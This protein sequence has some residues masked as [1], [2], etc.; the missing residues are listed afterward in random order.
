MVEQFT[1]ITASISFRNELNNNKEVSKNISMEDE[2]NTLNLHL[3]SNSVEMMHTSNLDESIQPLSSQ[4]PNPVI[5]STQN[6][7]SN[8]QF[9]LLREPAFIGK[10]DKRGRKTYAFIK[11]FESLIELDTFLRTEN[12]SNIITTHNT[13]VNCTQC[14][15]YKDCAKHKMVQMYRKC[16]CNKHECTLT[17]KINKCEYSKIWNLS[18]F[19]SHPTPCPMK[20]SSVDVRSPGKKAHKRY[21][22]A[23]I[24]QSIYES[25]LAKDN[26]MTAQQLLSKIV[27]RRKE[28][29]NKCKK[30]KNTKENKK[31]NEIKINMK[32]VFNKELLPSLTQ[33]RFIYLYIFLID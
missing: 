32:Y 29:T 13:N 22:V 12:S 20:D 6:P 21:G 19:G 15:N 4:E 7:K 17:Y 24:V 28:E 14:N 26:N 18:F 23:L 33:V 30:K 31:K 5:N 27:D 1:N 11:N 2:T 8:N 9:P 16:N 3:S 10:T 25:W